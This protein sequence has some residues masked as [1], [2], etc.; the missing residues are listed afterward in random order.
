MN[1]TEFALTIIPCININKNCQLNCLPSNKKLITALKFFDYLTVI[2]LA[3]IHI[4]YIIITQV[5]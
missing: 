5:N 1:N 4:T 3:S 2:Y